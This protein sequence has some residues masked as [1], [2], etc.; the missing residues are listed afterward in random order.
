M[1]KFIFSKEICFMVNIVV[2]KNYTGT[3]EVSILLTTPNRKL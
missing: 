3:Q 1:D 2:V